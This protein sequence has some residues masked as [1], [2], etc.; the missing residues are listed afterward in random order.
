VSRAAQLRPL[1]IASSKMFYRSLDT[2]VFALLSPFL[3]IAITALAQHLHFVFE[4]KAGSI[5]FFSFTA[6]GWAAFLG[7]HVNQDGTV[8]TASGYRAQGVLK[9]IA[10]TP[11]SP[12]MFIAAQVLTRLIV[13]LIQTILVLA[14]AVALGAA[15]NYSA[16]LAWLLPIA[17]IALLTGT[18]FGFAIAGLTRTPEAANQINITATAPVMLLGGITY[19]LQG[20]PG[21]LPHIAEYAVPFAA[22]IQAFREAAAGH[23][24]GDFPR[25]IV[26]SLAW[27]AVAAALAIRSYRLTD[28]HA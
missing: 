9:R 18:A 20:L 8:G 15:V 11:V 13:A 28:R 3:I 5:S 22:P 7:A 10:V 2:V 6:I 4:N 19:P 23:L 21:V 17:V 1:F 16:D 14:I 26:I 12:R 25:L 27:L 24:A